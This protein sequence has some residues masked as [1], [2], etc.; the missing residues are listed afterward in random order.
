MIVHLET[1]I[2]TVFGVLD[3]EG[4]AT[5]QEPLVAA[6]HKFS[7][8]AFTEAF[9]AIGDARDELAANTPDE[10]PVE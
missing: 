7:A 5:P 4:N 9:Q 1:R 6:V 3:D 8:D 10:E 2:Q